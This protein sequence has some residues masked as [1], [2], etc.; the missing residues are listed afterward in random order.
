VTWLLAYHADAEVRSAELLGVALVAA[1]ALPAAALL[2]R[3]PA[4][5]AG[6]ARRPS[7]VSVAC[8]G[9]VAFLALSGYSPVGF[10]LTPL[11]LLPGIGLAT[12]ITAA[13][14]RERD[15][16]TAAA[17]VAA[18]LVCSWVVGGAVGCFASD[19]CLH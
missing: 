14:R 8:S 11:L 18:A 4:A 7:L 9:I 17:V 5:G 1:V 6:D 16:L 15:R 10:V 2:L 3:R 13:R 12:A 19:G